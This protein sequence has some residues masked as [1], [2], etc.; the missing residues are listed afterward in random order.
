MRGVRRLTLSNILEDTLNIVLNG[1]R[2]QEGLGGNVTEFLAK[3]CLPVP[4]GAGPT[5]DAIFTPW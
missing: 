4:D 2:D 1:M 5:I 3:L